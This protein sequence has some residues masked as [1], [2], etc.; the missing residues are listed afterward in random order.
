MLWMNLF[1]YFR[2]LKQKIM[3]RLGRKIILYI[4]MVTSVIFISVSCGTMNSMQRQEDRRLAKKQ[5]EIGKTQDDRSNEY[6]K[7]IE[8]QERIQTKETRKRMRELEKKSKRWRE[9]KGAPFY[10]RWIQKWEEA[11]E[12]RQQRRRD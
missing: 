3:L 6:L 7:Q 10:E 9:G 2:I 1:L 8:R 12:N 5:K 4:I 11:K